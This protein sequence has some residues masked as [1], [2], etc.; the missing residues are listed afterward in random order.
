VA[1][2]PAVD[3][4]LIDV[5]TE[6]HGEHVLVRRL[7][8]EDA[9]A[10]FAAIVASRA[11]LAR[12]MPWA[13]DYLGVEDA[14][15][16][17]RRSQA[18]WILR[19][20]LP[21]GIFSAADAS[22]L[23]G[24]GLERINWELRRFEIGYWLVATAQGHG[25]VTETVQLLTRVCFRQLGARRVQIR[26]DPRNLRSEHVPQRLGFTFEGTLRNVFIDSEGAPADRHIYALTPE[27]YARLP[28]ADRPTA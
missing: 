13:A 21:V 20:R 3:P 10:L 27:T 2:A 23:G 7:E 17:I 25:Y 19:E 1:N 12:W 11:H 14:L 6:L 28:W 5:P 9:P 8:D 16:Y 15:R 18:H 26:M 22:L 4:L 24:S